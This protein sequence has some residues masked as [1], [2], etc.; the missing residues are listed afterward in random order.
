MTSIKESF[1]AGESILSITRKKRPKYLLE[2]PNGDSYNLCNASQIKVL[3]DSSGHTMPLAAIYSDIEGKPRGSCKR[4]RYDGI[5]IT[6]LPIC[7]TANSA[8]APEV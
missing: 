7:T 2:L 1:I 8:D 4:R 6:K 5:S 3:L